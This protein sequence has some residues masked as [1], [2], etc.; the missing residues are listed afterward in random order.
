[1]SDL[2]AQDQNTNSE[3]CEDR[4]FDLM[5]SEKEHVDEQISSFMGIQMKILAFLFPA[6]GLATGWLFGD[7]KG[8]LGHW[9]QGVVLLIVV[10]TSC[11]GILLSVAA[12]CV[13][14]EYEH[15]KQAALVPRFNQLL[16]RE[17]KSLFGREEWGKGHASTVLVLSLTIFWLLIFSV[18]TMLLA[19]AHEFMVSSGAQSL[20]SFW[21]V[22]AF[23]FASMAV[24]VV[25][26]IA[27]LP[28]VKTR[29]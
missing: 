29:R 8:T 19:K 26:F 28:G 13:A 5:K 16:R 2:P 14:M 25:A 27:M 6:L 10:L 18:I 23:V 15:Y 24:V 4:L 9:E 11:F 22:A 17:Q 1:M 12:Y 7:G 20:K 21:A 3:R